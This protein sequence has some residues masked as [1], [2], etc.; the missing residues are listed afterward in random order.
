MKGAKVSDAV[1]CC[2]K[3]L[4]DTLEVKVFFDGMVSKVYD[5][6]TW[7][8]HCNDERLT[9]GKRSP[10]SAWIG[11]YAAFQLV[12]KV[13]SNRSF[14]SFDISRPSTVV[15]EAENQYYGSSDLAGFL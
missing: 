10:S 2:T 14:H 13:C 8:F 1:P 7:K 11:H 5:L 6:G 9:H 12:I 4:L 15:E 3:A